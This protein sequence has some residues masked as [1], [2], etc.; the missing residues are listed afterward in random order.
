MVYLDRSRAAAARQSLLRWYRRRSRALPW[1][2]SG[3][4][5]NVWLSEVMLQQ[6]QIETVIP[7]YQ[8]F[9]RQ[10]PTVEHLASAPLER[11]LELWSGLGYYRRARNLHR[12]AQEI[13][14][15]HGGQ[16]PNQIMLARSLPGVGEYTARA[17]L[18]IAYNQPFA[19]LDGN[20]ARVMARFLALR[21][22]L[23]QPRFR[24]TIEENLAS[25]LSRRSP[26]NFN[27]AMMELGQTVCLPRSPQCSLCPLRHWC[28]GFQ[29]D[30]PENYPE[31]RPRRPAE[32]WH[33][34]AAVLYKNQQ[35]LLSKG[36]EEGILD[37][38][39]NFPSALGQSSNE[40]LLL[41]EEK[42]RTLLGIVPLLE[43]TAHQLRHNITYRSIQVHVYKGYLSR[44][45]AKD[46]FRW[47]Q[48]RSVE[49]AAVSQLA[50]KIAK[51][52]GDTGTG[53]SGQ[54]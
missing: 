4:P 43:R 46:G 32:K 38:L 24:R 12:A 3:A 13:V 33:M 21:G 42:L 54:S 18:S 27:Q 7:Y 23:P 10:F 51:E 47:F 25:L 8:R 49:Q 45:T 19:V 28:R 40:A 20:V 44:R 22:S 39:W 50:R 9:L 30:Q 11:V 2:K 37:D 52:I 1:R 16:F 41:L 34:A 48:P 26:G 14:E 53:G 36:L 29:S 15:K 17:V 31:P 35:V 5:Y 6:T